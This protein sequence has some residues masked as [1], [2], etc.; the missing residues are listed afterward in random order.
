MRLTILSIVQPI[1]RTSVPCP[2]SSIE[3]SSKATTSSLGGCFRR[4]CA[5]SRERTRTRTRDGR[6]VCA[7]ACACIG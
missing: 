2:L 3:T 7:R 4:V 1:N 6:A 5:K